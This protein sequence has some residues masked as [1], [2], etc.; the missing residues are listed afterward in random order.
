MID[1]MD[2]LSF[3]I[4]IDFLEIQEYVQFLTISKGIFDQAEQY[5]DLRCPIIIAVNKRYGGY[6][7]SLQCKEEMRFLGYTENP[8]WYEDNRRNPF[9]IR[10]ILRIGS[11][12][13]SREYASLG[14]HAF[15]RTFSRCI[16]IDE[17]D[18]MESP[19][20]DE[21]KYMSQVIEK[22]KDHVN[23][24]LID[25]KKD[26]EAESFRKIVERYDFLKNY[27]PAY[28]KHMQRLDQWLTKKIGLKR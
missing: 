14:L 9:L 16:K 22:C 24:T 26:L 19:D 28:D 17:Y 1:Q 2:P 3:K 23:D 4:L 7:I 8:P 25:K 27:V 5:Q 15:P 11:E 20:I 21:Y 6:G 13:A 18:G 10:A 12:K